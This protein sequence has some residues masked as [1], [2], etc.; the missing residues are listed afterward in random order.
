[1]KKIQTKPKRNFIHFSIQILKI[2]MVSRLYMVVQDLEPT[3]KQK[4]NQNNNLGYYQ[5]SFKMYLFLSL[6]LWF[7]L[8]YSFINFFVGYNFQTTL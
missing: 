3:L 5:I 2:Y 8:T 6:M 7:D 4:T 1:M